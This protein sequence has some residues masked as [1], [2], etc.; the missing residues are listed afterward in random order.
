VLIRLMAG[1]ALSRIGRIL[2]LMPVVCGHRPDRTARCRDGARGVPDATATGSPPPVAPDRR[3]EGL[4]MN[5]LTQALEFQSQALL[6]RADR[7]GLLASNIANAD[8]PGYEAREM[9][10]ARALREATG[11]ASEPPSPPLA[12]TD[13]AHVAQPVFSDETTST[14]I[15][16]RHSQDAVD[17]NTVDLDRERASMAENTVKYEA[18]LRFINGSLRTLGD[19][20]KSHNQG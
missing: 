9:D 19:A 3:P 12:V 13:A 17:R 15:W 10:F 8:T 14:L 2:P 4:A 5:R 11:T 18:A 16:A 20:M 7:Q 1:R 6:L